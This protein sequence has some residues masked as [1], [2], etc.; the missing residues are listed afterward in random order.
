LEEPRPD[1]G[2]GV[3]YELSTVPRYMKEAPDKY[4]IVILKIADIPSTKIADVNRGILMPITRGVGISN[5]K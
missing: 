5:C 2:A 1:L 3:E 4:R